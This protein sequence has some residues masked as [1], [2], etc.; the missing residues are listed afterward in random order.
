MLLPIQALYQCV[1]AFHPLYQ[2]M[3]AP[4]AVIGTVAHWKAAE[5]YSSDTL[6]MFRGSSLPAVVPDNLIIFG[7][8]EI[9][10][11]HE[12]RTGLN[13]IV[14]PEQ[15]SEADLFCQVC[16]LLLGEDTDRGGGELLSA[17]ANGKR[18][19][20]VAEVGYR[21][22]G[23][24]IIISDKNWRALAMVP[25]EDRPEDVD[26]HE[27]K[28]NGMLSL[29]IVTE[30]LEMNLIPMLAEATG[31]FYWKCDRIKYARLFCNIMMG[32]RSVATL[33][34]MEQNRPFTKQ[35]YET[36]KLLS[37]AISAEMQKTNS[38]H[39][40]RG[41]EYEE[42]FSDLLAGRIE[43]PV[44]IQKR[45]KRLNLPI[46][47][48]QYV[49]AVDITEIDERKSSY[50][51]ICD[52]LEKLIPNSKAL[53][54]KEYIILFKSYSSHSGAMESDFEK[55]EKFACYYHARCGISRRFQKMNEVR[56]HYFQAV[57]ALKLG[58]QMN[59]EL[60]MCKYDD[61]AIYHIAEICSKGEDLQKLCHPKLLYLLEYDREHNTSF[62]ESL[63]AY[64]KNARN[65]TQTAAAVHLHRNSMIYHIKKIEEVL[66]ISLADTDMLLYFELSFRFLEYEKKLN[67]TKV[68]EPSLQE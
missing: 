16:N 50:T 62:T 30:N 63:Y 66:D 41:L 25:D 33:S 29:N 6:C 26:W 36:I 65:I 53:V 23:N 38:L 19:I 9:P 45:A 55:L 11:E 51:F 14:L 44:L 56:K 48:C 43:D 47:D 17:L 22:L 39:F 32:G 52:Y 35:D 28:T 31:P 46:K 68:A 3:G 13:L 10:K 18:L 59:Q 21:I 64:L 58:Y 20:S 12:N 8:V 1:E 61:L 2:F 34:V 42:F 54:F 7:K 37:N 15:V 40:A 5:T 67:L 24:P 60:V 57:E 27:F 4:E 49:T